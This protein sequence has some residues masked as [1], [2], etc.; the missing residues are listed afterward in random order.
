MCRVPA[1]FGDEGYLGAAA[2]QPERDEVA[3]ALQRAFLAGDEE[4]QTENAA[5]GGAPAGIDAVVL[6]RTGM[7]S[8]GLPSA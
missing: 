3:A 8:A 5:S 4:V 6:L 2:A 7:V 1:V